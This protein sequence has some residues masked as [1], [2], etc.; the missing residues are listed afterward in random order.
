[1]EEDA[2]ALSEDEIDYNVAGSFPASDPPSWTLGADR[3]HRDVHGEEKP[4]PEEP[5]HQNEPASPE[6]APSSAIARAAPGKALEG[7]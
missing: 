3:R 1:M 2:D 4:S 6:T 7:W 5:T